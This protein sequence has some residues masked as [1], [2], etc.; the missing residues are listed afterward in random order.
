MHDARLRLP[1]VRA[2]LMRDAREFLPDDGRVWGVYREAEGK[3]IVHVA[4]IDDA[5][6]HDVSGGP[7]ACC[8]R[9]E[10]AGDG[11]VIV[12]DALDGRK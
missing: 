3:A 9:V 7:C 6:E 1:D 4:P 8:P 11:V 12:H 5:I 10:D 2:P